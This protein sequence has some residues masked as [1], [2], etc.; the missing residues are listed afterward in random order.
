MC[1]SCAFT[2]IND[3]GSV[4]S[5]KGKLGPLLMGGKTVDLFNKAMEQFKNELVD[6]LEKRLWVRLEERIRR[7]RHGTTLSI[8]EAAEYMHMSDRTLRRMVQKGN[9][10]F[11]FT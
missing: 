1:E 10:T 8:Y 3:Y 9:S 4:R 6:E 2:P 7:N 5:L 11:S